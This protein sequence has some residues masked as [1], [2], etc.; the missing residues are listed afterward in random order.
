MVDIRVGLEC[1]EAYRPVRLETLLPYTE[2]NVKSGEICNH[3]KLEVSSLSK[4]TPCP[5]ILCRNFVPCFSGLPAS[6]L[7]SM[8]LVQTN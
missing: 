4:P 1:F 5:I 7:D 3:L 8:P 2:L 6:A